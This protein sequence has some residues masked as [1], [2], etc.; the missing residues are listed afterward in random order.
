MLNI[1]LWIWGGVGL[2]LSIGGLLDEEGGKRDLE[3]A[4]SFEDYMF[5]LFIFVCALIFWP[6]LPFVA[7]YEWMK[8]KI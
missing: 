3:N 6:V 4:Q 2:F 8:W 1:I 7:L 5:V